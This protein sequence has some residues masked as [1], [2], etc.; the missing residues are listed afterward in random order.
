MSIGILIAFAIEAGIA[1]QYLSGWGIWDALA[2]WVVLL[3]T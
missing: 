1:A 3:A 2:F